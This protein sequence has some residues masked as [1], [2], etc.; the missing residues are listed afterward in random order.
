MHGH[1]SVLPRLAAQLDR[2]LELRKLASPNAPEFAFQLPGEA[3]PTTKST[4]SWLARALEL[5]GV[6]APPGFA[7]QG[8]SLRSL[9][10]SA[11]AAIGVPRHVYVWLGGWTRGSGVVDKHYID[12]TFQPSPAAFSLLGWAL[13]LLDRYPPYNVWFYHTIREITGRYSWQLVSNDESDD[14]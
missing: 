3:R 7:F 2:Y 10:T 6:T 5:T 11:C 13:R 8:H 4:E 9:G 12:P 1:P 14:H